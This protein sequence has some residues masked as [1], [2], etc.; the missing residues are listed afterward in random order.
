MPGELKLCRHKFYLF[1]ACVTLVLNVVART[2]PDKENNQACYHFAGSR[3]KC[4]GWEVKKDTHS[5]HKYVPLAW[6]GQD[7]LTY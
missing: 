6:H 1:S 4:I 7:V 2:V 3:Y 5:G